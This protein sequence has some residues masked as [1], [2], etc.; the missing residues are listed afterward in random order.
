MPHSNRGNFIKDGIAQ[1][2]SIY[3]HRLSLYFPN[4]NIERILSIQYL[5]IV[6]AFFIALV[7]Y[8]Y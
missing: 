7:V 1:I 3:M 2:L 6:Y 4:S 8:S 5:T